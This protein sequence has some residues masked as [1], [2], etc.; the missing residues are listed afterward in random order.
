MGL[1]TPWSIWEI[2]DQSFVLLGITH[3]FKPKA[4]SSD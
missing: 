2:C 4:S 1:K 3:M